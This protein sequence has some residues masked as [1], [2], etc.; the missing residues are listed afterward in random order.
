MLTMKPDRSLVWI[1]RLP[2]PDANHDLDEPHHRHR[3][4]EVQ[5]EHAVGPARPGADLGDRDR[6]GVR[7]QEAGVR[8]QF[9]ERL[10]QLALHARVLDD[11]LHHAVDVVQVVERGR[12]GDPRLEP[13]RVLRAHLP[14]RDRAIRRLRQPRAGAHQRRLL[15][16]VDSDVDAGGGARLRDPG[17]HEARAD[18]RYSRYLHPSLLLHLI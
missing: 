9:V 14:A 7:R 2:I 17:A 3:R 1:G 13:L 15:G 18:D 12:V 6:R 11:S 8:Q 5:P 10:E 16:L 4:E